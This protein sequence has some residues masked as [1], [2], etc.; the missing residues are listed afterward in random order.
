MSY[1]AKI[2]V[3]VAALSVGQQAHAQGT[4]Y[5]SNL[6]QPSAGTAFLGSDS[7]IAQNFGTGTNPGGYILDSV[8]LLMA[9]A[10]GNPSGFSLA[11][12]SPRSD[13][14]RF[15]GESLGNLTGPDPAA[16][17]TFSY[18]GAGFVLAAH[19][20]YFLV[21]SATT[22]I[23]DGAYSWSL[24]DSSSSDANDGWR[25]LTF[26]WSTVDGVNWD[27]HPGDYFQFAVNATAVPEPSAWL[28]VALGLAG[29][30]C[31][32]NPLRR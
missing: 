11:L 25:V 24:A 7:W 6:G 26:Q 16:G 20:P 10:A 2:L 22:P 3:A 8:E 5:L 31:W 19:T 4:T 17:G 9:P 1:F 32:R 13:D 21:L 28:L 23:A 30:G 12:Y 27:R 29:L 15:P 18:S 14:G